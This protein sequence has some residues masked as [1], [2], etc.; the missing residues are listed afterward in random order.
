[1]KILM[2]SNDQAFLGVAT[3]TGDAITRHKSYGQLVEKLS[4]IVL[5]KHR[6]FVPNILSDNVRAYPTNS[7]SVWQ[8]LTDALAVGRDLFES[9]HYD[10]LVCQDPFLTGL[11]GYFLK[12]KFGAKLLVDFHG[13]FWDNHYWLEEN[14]LHRPMLAV[15]RFVVAHSDALRVVSS[16]VKQKLLQHKIKKPIEVIPTPVNLE[17]F[18]TPDPETV[19]S[20]KNEFLGQKI[21]L[22]TGRLSVEKN[23][24]F[25]ILSFAKI[26]AKYPNVVLLIAGSGP[27][28]TKLEKLI[29]SLKLT[30]KI[31]L[32]GQTSYQLLINYFHSADIFV[33]P[34]RHESF[35]KVLLEAG[36][37]GKPTV[38]SAT[39]GAKEVIV[40][41]E[42]GFLFPVNKS[43]KFVNQI[44][45]LLND[46]NLAHQIGAKA[47]QHIH[48]KY[49]WDNSLKNVVAYWQ[50]VVADKK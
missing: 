18:K 21:I 15:S 50:K 12:K 34:S 6:G 23:L 7:F 5:T 22:W 37:S 20:I 29:T 49:N 4:I 25:L 10:L 8:N 42:T 16:G 40:D 32:L 14:I 17:N 33:L 36:A 48:Q 27:E 38:A 35:G 11:I 41:G 46:E 24:S 2:I 44:L 19:A 47:F 31:K 39:T 26:I 28:K 3:S 9:D 45:T 13:D 1:M 43:K 30:D